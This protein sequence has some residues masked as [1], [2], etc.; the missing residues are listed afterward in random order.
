MKWED[1]SIDNAADF[2]DTAIVGGYDIDESDLWIIR[3]RFKCEVIPGKLNQFHKLAFIAYK[4]Q[5]GY[6][7]K[8]IDYFE[9]NDDNFS[10]MV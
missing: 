9:V 2:M 1:T 3:A 7:E 6:V 10:L 8:N 4:T 5:E